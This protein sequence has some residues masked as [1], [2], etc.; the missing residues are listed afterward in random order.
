MV[1]EVP[2]PRSV[3]SY[4]RFVEFEII[5]TLCALLHKFRAQD[6]PFLERQGLNHVYKNSDR[7]CDA[8]RL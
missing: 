2:R 8:C 3:N 4:P 7:P 5:L 6:L 1:R